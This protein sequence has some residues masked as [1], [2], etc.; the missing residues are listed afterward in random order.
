M[1]HSTTNARKAA[2]HTDALMKMRFDIKMPIN[3]SDL[4]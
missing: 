3:P 1:T 2:A 4:K